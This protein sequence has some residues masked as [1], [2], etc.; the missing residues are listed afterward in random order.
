MWSLLGWSANHHKFSESGRNHYD[1]EVLS[2]KRPNASENSTITADVGQQKRAHASLRQ[3]QITRR[4]TNNVV[5]LEL[6]CVWI[7]RLYFATI[8]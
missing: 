4:T 7:K 2:T 8:F 3:R 5:L 1:S 6:T